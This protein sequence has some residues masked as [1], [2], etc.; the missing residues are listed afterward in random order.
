MGRTGQLE[1][2]GKVGRKSKGNFPEMAHGPYV[3]T[4]VGR[5]VGRTNISNGL[6]SRLRRERRSEAKEGMKE[7]RQLAIPSTIGVVACNSNMVQRAEGNSLFSSSSQ[8]EY[9]RPVSLTAIGR[10]T[11]LMCSRHT[12]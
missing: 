1:K 7:K 12:G 2:T 4:F 5:S 3:C 10:S 9:V 8:E 11:R 6:A